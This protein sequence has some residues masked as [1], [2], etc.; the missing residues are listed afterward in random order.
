MLFRSLASIPWIIA[1]GP[2]AF[3]SIGDPAQPGTAL[4]QVGGAV[5]NA[6]VLEVPT[7]TPLGEIVAAAGG[8]AKG[9]AIK[10]LLVG[11][12]SGGFVPAQLLASTPYSGAGLRAVGAHIGS[13][14]ILAIDQSTSIPEFAAM[15]VRWCA[16]EACGK[17][18]PCRIGTRRQIGRAHV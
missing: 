11:G 16:D 6:G 3:R 9:A 10:A 12:P 15:L 13:G 1:R 18:I 5:S 4:V 7:G 8:A 14:A 2:E 17:T